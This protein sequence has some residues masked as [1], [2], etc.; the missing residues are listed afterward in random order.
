MAAAR[1]ER[2]GRPK[3]GGDGS[4]SL[5]VRYS[6]TRRATRGQGSMTPARSTRQPHRRRC[7]LCG[8][9]LL[10]PR[11]SEPSL[12]PS[13]PPGRSPHG[14]LLDGNE[15]HIFGGVQDGLHGAR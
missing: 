6:S 13:G 14:L 2:R 9:L 15:A 4:L 5:S 12:T 7:S 10:R 8:S 1:G 3:Q 11:A